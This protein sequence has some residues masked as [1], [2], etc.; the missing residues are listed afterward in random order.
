MTL[1]LNFDSTKQSSTEMKLVVLT[2]DG[3]CIGNPGPGGWACILRHKGHCRELSGHESQTTNNRMEMRAV[4]EGREPCEV[5]VRTDSQ[6]LRDGITAWIYKWKANG[7]M[8]KV[9]RE[10]KQPVRN[11]DLWEEI[12]QLQQKH[13][14]EWVWVKGHAEDVDNNR[15]DALANLAAQRGR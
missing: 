13:R 9:K 4:I 14:V 2:T 10:G 6:Y 8:H 3:A 7:W 11:R 12:D 15:C 5:L 1:K